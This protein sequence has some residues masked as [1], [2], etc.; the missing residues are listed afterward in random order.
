MSQSQAPPRASHPHQSPRTTHLDGHYQQR[1]QA[2]QQT[3]MHAPHSDS[4]PGADAALAAAKKKK[5]K[6]KGKRVEDGYETPD[7]RDVHQQQATYQQ[8]GGVPAAP[9]QLPQGAY[10]AT[11]QAQADLLAT[12]SDLYRRIEADPQGLPDDD[13]Y[14]TSLPAHLRTFI[15]NALPLGKFPATTNNDPNARHASTQ[16]MI[17]VAQQLAQAAHATQRHLYPSLP[18]DP[19]IFADLALHSDQPMPLHNHPNGNNPSVPG[20]PVY[21]HAHFSTGPNAPPTQPPGEPL[22][23]LYNDYA[24]ETGD[25]EEDYYDEDEPDGAN[26]AMTD[27]AHPL[28][29]DVSQWRTESGRTVPHPSVNGNGIGSVQAPAAAKKKNK[30][31]KKKT[32]AMT[33][34]DAPAAPPTPVTPAKQPSTYNPAQHNN[35]ALPSG[36]RASPAGAPRSGVPPPSSR[37]AGKQP[38]TF[39]SNAA[40]KAAP[41]GHSHPPAPKRSASSVTGP[42]GN[43]ANSSAPGHSHPHG[44]PHPPPQQRIWSTSTAEERERIKDFWLGLTDSERRN[45]VQVEKQAVLT[46]MKESQK[47]TCTCAVC[48]RK[49]SAIESELE[50]LYNM[51]FEELQQ[52]ANHQ[53]QY[54]KS[55]GAIPPPP[56]PGPFPGSIALDSAGNVIGG[57]AL[58]K[59]PAAQKPRTAIPQ[60]KALPLPEDDDEYDD[61]LDDED[62][63]DDYDEEEEDD[64]D[65]VPP[66]DNTNRRRT[67]AGNQAPTPTGNDVFPL[68][69]SLTVKGAYCSIVMALA[70]I[71]G[72]KLS[73]D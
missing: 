21:S 15:R 23:L 45:L 70:Q 33:S 68:G 4:P 10:A 55:A 41:N 5:K 46:K 2:Q 51:Y 48:G 63:D 61:D 34:T 12:A 13:A 47:H 62:Y 8:S 16:A 53:Q 39:N 32:A 71:H 58:T 18:F 17:A 24:D 37:A 27:G 60:K 19:A 54:V 73:R 26:G 6:G 30:K 66:P 9:N 20:Q 1:H 42:H 65:D 11:A 43:A 36:G 57:N 59:A 14:W 38:M 64:E 56:G 29:H 40:S 25:Y 50:V 3:Q 28:M 52:Y 72:A 49:R 67:P 22:P 44:P 7:S 35:G 69:T 31:K